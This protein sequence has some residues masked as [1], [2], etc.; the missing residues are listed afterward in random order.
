MLGDLRFAVRSLLRHAGT[1]TVAV[2]SLALG[3]MATTAIYSVVHAV[4]LDPFPYKDVD[5]LMSVRVAARPAGRPHVLL[6]RS[7][8]RDRR[9]QHDLRRRDRFHHQRRVVDGQ[10]ASRSGYA[11]THGTPNTFE[12]MGVPPLVGRTFRPA[13]VGADAAPVVVL[14]Y[15]SGNAS[16]AATERRRPELRSNGGSHGRR[17]HAEAVHVARRGCLPAGYVQAR[18]AIEGIRG[19]H[20]L[21]RLKPNVSEAQAEPIS[22]RSSRT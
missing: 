13:D 19:V 16:S 2:L 3:M 18:R 12:V 7:V 11:A 9:A 4:V 15:G 5:N 6:D 22:G 1:T 14:G 17:R 21:G 8:S 10:A 20:L